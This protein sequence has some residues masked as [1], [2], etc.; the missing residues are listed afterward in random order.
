MN[1]N[2]I[3][4]YVVNEE[5]ETEEKGAASCEEAEKIIEEYIESQKGLEGSAEEIAAGS[6][7]GFL[8]DERTFMEICVYGDKEYR[9]KFECPEPRSVL[10]VRWEGVYSREIGVLDRDRLKEIVREFYRREVEDFK[11][12]FSGLRDECV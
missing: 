11:R 2:D 6:M 10:F 1:E 4:W 8:H 7:F 3:N 9:V 5:L 12:Y